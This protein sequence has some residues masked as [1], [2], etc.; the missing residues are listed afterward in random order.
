MKDKYS[1]IYTRSKNLTISKEETEKLVKQ[2]LQDML[3]EDCNVNTDGIIEHVRFYPYYGNNLND[4][5]K[6]TLLNKASEEQ[7]AASIILKSLEK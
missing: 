1:I 3:G 7:K 4:P 5:K 2:Y 6:I